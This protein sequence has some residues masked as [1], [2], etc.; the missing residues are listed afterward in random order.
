M[1]NQTIM[2]ALGITQEDVQTEEGFYKACELV[3]N[4]SYTV[5]GSPYFP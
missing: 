4:S 2:D 3:K 1:F 5:D